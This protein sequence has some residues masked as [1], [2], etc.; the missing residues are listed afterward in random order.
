MTNGP[1]F[2]LSLSVCMIFIIFIISDWMVFAVLWQHQLGKSDSQRA[3]CALVWVPS[4]VFVHFQNGGHFQS[5]E[6]KGGGEGL[7]S[8]RGRADSI[9]CCS[10]ASLE[11]PAS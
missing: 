8:S 1:L 5:F 10:F 2:D 9:Y 4:L 7:W 3:S 11:V 6:G